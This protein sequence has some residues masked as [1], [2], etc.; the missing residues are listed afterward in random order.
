[1]LRGRVSRSHAAVNREP[2]RQKFASVLPILEP[3]LDV[4]APEAAFYLWPCLGRDDAN[5]TRELY[6]RKNVLTLP[7]SFLA[8]DGRAGNPG[9]ERLRISL[10]PGVAECN[11]AAERIRDFVNGR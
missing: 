8:R 7:G 3:V 11:A 4:A 1:M 9:H 2:Y 5:F 10:V 6:A